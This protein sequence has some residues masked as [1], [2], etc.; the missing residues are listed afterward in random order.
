MD[1]VFL[2]AACAN[3]LADSFPYNYVM[4]V[5]TNLIEPR[6]GKRILNHLIWNNCPEFGYGLLE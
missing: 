4:F 3:S 1:L 5:L 6:M 2:L